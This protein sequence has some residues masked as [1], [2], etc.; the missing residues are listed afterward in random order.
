MMSTIESIIR[1]A[2]VYS[3][4]PSVTTETTLTS[5]IERYNERVNQLNRMLETSTPDNPLVS[6][7]QEELTRDKVRILQN[8]AAVRQ[9]LEA[10]RR[11]IMAIKN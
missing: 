2:D 5:I 3:N 4:V 7:L 9:S 1:Q 6:S 8:I 11:S 10:R